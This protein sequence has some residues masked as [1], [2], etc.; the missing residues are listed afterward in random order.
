M[1]NSWAAGEADLVVR[2]CPTAVS[3]PA[4]PGRAPSA[5][6]HVQ[7]ETA[8]PG[9]DHLS[10]RQPHP[11]FHDQLPRMLILT[12]KIH[13]VEPPASRSGHFGRPSGALPPSAYT[14]S[15]TSQ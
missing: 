11:V 13:K 9:A 3:R 8:Q 14:A 4:A 6:G 7:V 10:A 2:P 12:N 15:F 5:A 1:I